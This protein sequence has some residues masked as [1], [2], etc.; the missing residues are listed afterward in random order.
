MNEEELTIVEPKIDDE[1][2]LADAQ[3]MAE[4]PPAE[5]TDVSEAEAGIGADITRFITKA[6]GIHPDVPISKVMPSPKAKV[7]AE[8]PTPKVDTPEPTVEAPKP[9]AKPTRMTAWANREIL[10]K[11]PE[12]KEKKIGEMVVSKPRA[13][14]EAEVVPMPNDVNPDAMFTKMEQGTSP[15]FAKFNPEKEAANLVEADIDQFDDSVSH[16]INFNTLENEDDVNSVIASIA[17]QNKANIDFERR[18]VVSDDQLMKFAN[19]IGADE[20]FVR[21]VFMREAGGAI[22]PA[23]YVVAMRQVLNQSATKLKMLADKVAGEFS[24]QDKIEFARQ[25]DFHRKFQSKFMGVRAEYGRGLRALGVQMGN[26]NDVLMTLGAMERELDITKVAAMISDSESATGI[27]K[28]VNA[29]SSNA[30]YGMDLLYT[31]YMSSMLSGVSTQMLNFGGTIANISVNMAERKVASWMPKGAHAMDEVQNDEVT[32]ML[33]GYSSSFKDAMKAGWKTLKTGDPYKGMGATGEAF[34]M[35]M[36]SEKFAMGETSGAVADMAFKAMA[37]PLRNV[38]GST[39]TFFKV[40]N[41]RAQLASN[42]FR[43]AKAMVNRG[44]IKPEQFQE[45]LASII[46]NPHQSMINKSEDFSKE[47][48][49]QETPGKMLTNIMSAINKT[50]GA[51]WVVPFVKTLGN[52]TRQTL[53]ERGPFAWMQQKFRDDYNAGGAK[54]QLVLAKMSMGTGFMAGAY[55]LAESGSL[56]GPAPKDKAERDA[57][58]AAG[59]KPFSVVFN[60]E[61][62]TKEYVPYTGLEPFATFFGIAAS[63]SDYQRKSSYVDLYDGEDEKFN[64]V[65]SDLLVAISENTL[66]RTFAVGLQTFMDAVSEGDAKSFQRLAQSYANTMIPLAGLRR[67]ITK[68]MDEYKRNTAGVMEYIQSQIPTMSEALPPVRDLFGEPVT[69][70]YTYIRWSPSTSTKDPVRLELLRLNEQTKKMAVP[71]ARAI[72]GKQKIKPED[73]EKWLTYA[74]KE[75]RDFSGRT[76][77]ER[78]NDTIQDENYLSMLEDDKVKHIQSITQKND[79]AALKELSKEDEE[80]FLRLHAKDIVRSANI[81]IEKENMDKEDALE[82]AKQEYEDIFG[83]R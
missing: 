33:I 50:P 22:P 71:P 67:N 12:P 63:I 69:H 48:A 23:E 73:S 9:K 18:G 79:M 41:E 37:F 64:S 66:N 54:R 56:T 40:L 52:I 80:L 36:P 38:M 15:K 20:T 65:M 74:R 16:Q 45:T 5:V 26:E 43:E 8:I 77:H 46:N 14:H 6:V 31:E 58:K 10:A 82:E 39:D 3:V 34:T 19:D 62:G 29:Y 81:L 51:R 13:V 53:V 32:A 83:G 55:M 42:S 30:K 27:N 17:E 35:P 24:P 78:I 75:Y 59:M 68:D 76:L 44:E 11:K 2:A 47:M 7:S 49:Y 21:D 25:F 61:D 1:Q 72:L 4:M 70:D 28:M 60:N 57:W